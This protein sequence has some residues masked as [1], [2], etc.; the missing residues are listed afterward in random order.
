MENQLCQFGCGTLAKFHLKNGKAC[1]SEKIQKCKAIRI[2][3]GKSNR[4]LT[5][6]TCEFIKNR[7]ELYKSKINSGE[8]KPGFLGRHHTEETKRKIIE[9][10]KDHSGK[11]K[12]GRYKGYWCDSSWELAWII[13]HLEHGIKFERNKEGFEYNYNGKTCRYYPDFKLEDETYIEIKGYFREKTKEK[14]ESFPK[15]LMVLTGPEMKPILNYVKTKYGNNFIKLYED[16]EI[17]K[18]KTKEEIKEE[19]NKNRR[20]LACKR[21]HHRIEAV[22]NS[23]IDFKKFGW[24]QKVSELIK[25]QP[26]RVN[27]FMKKFCQEILKNAFKKQSKTLR[28]RSSIG[29]ECCPVTAEVASLSLVDSATI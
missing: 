1:C 5:K 12:H 11:G 17:K 6:E 19:V 15:K 22:K 16:V 25:I 10:R 4:G 8:I 18:I 26:Q 20:L 29:L 27:K 7:A 14:L 3:V 23:N 9:K 21:Q 24:V 13:Y 2:K 28:S